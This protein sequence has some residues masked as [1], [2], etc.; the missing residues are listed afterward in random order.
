MG[1]KYVSKRPARHYVREWLK[2]AHI[3]QGGLARLMNQDPGTVSKWFSDPQRLHIGTLTDIAAV[4]SELIPGPPIRAADLLRPP[5][6]VQAQHA[7]AA[8]TIP[9]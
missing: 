8:S 9:R 1:N 3:D 5:A 4:L 2:I 7:F 6:E